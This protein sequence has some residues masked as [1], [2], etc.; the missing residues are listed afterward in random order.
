M[1]V[2]ILRYLRA[3]EIEDDLRKIDP[4]TSIIS[5]PGS[6]ERRRLRDLL[7]RTAVP[8]EAARYRLW[9]WSDWRR[10]LSFIAGRT[11]EGVRSPKGQIDPPDHWLVLRH[12]LSGMT[13]GR[14]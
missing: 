14:A 2:R 8:E 3:P 6:E 4:S 10:E 9:T 1:S 7:E 12:I 13:T 11:P 5:I